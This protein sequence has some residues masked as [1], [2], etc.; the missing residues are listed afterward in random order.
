MENISPASPPQ[1]RTPTASRFRPAL[2]S[3][4]TSGTGGVS[5]K[6]VL[7]TATT[8]S[9]RLC[10]LANARCSLPR[11]HDELQQSR[12]RKRTGR[13]AGRERTHTQLGGTKCTGGAGIQNP[14]DREYLGSY[15]GAFRF[16][17]SSRDI[18][19]AKLHSMNRGAGR[20]EYEREMHGHA[21][22]LGRLH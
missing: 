2:Y 7:V 3:S 9:A 1:L 5:K 18:L 16:I 15:F 19:L 11:C 14:V 12:Q 6:V 17:Q 20:G 8:T 13:W 21:R 10:R 22:L 4:G